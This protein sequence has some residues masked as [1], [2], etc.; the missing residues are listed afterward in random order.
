MIAFFPPRRDDNLL[1]I[2]PKLFRVE[3]EVIHTRSE[4]AL[5]LGRMVN[6]PL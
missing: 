1:S 2:S 4:K 6:D 3:E 5:K